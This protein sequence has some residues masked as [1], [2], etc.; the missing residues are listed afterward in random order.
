[1]TKRRPTIGVTGEIEANGYFSVRAEYM[2][3]VEKAGGVPVLLPPSPGDRVSALLGAVDGLM[4]TGGDDI[5]PS[6]YGEP[7]HPTSKWTRERDDFELAIAR[8]AVERDMPLLAI[9]RGQQLLNV[10]LGGTLVQD[11]PDQLPHAGTHKLRGVPRWQIAHEVEVLP[12]TKLRQILGSDLLSVNSFHHQAVRQ[13]GRGL[14]LAARSRDGVVE[15]LELPDRRFVVSVQ[16]HPEAM[17]N[18]EPDH[19]ELFR[20][21]LDSIS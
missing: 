20:A 16:W 15:G 17:W 19:Q 18:Q 4:L 3:A 21:F 9:C 1:M 14:R 6:L 13:L 2:R 5:D 11:I 10:A 8:D 7:P 12:G